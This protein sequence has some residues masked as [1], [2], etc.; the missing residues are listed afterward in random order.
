MGY[1][2]TLV[3]PRLQPLPPPPPPD[4]C[5]RPQMY[6][7]YREDLSQF[8]KCEA[9]RSSALPNSMDKDIARVRTEHKRGT[10]A[11]KRRLTG[12]QS[13]TH[14]WPLVVLCCV[15]WGRRSSTDADN[16]WCAQITCRAFGT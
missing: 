8:A 10:W 15:V 7:Q 6:G 14:S 2:G 1:E 3:R 16:A 11:V 5:R 13:S 9:R 4:D 12:S